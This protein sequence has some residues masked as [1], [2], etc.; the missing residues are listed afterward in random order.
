MKTPVWATLDQVYELTSGQLYEVRV[1]GTISV[2]MNS[3]VK[4][5]REGFKVD[6]H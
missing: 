4:C 2:V 6:H 3:V 1:T 5:P